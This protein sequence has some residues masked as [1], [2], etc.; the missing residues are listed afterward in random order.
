MTIALRA[1]LPLQGPRKSLGDTATARP[2]NA[3]SIHKTFSHSIA[4]WRSCAG[5][6]ECMEGYGECLVWAW[7]RVGW[8]D[9]A[10]FLHQPSIAGWADKVRRLKL[11]PRALLLRVEGLA[12]GGG[13]P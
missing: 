6:G 2:L 3:A 12:A 5:M 7:S 11:A 8:S 9:L 10:P 1:G 13:A 4:P